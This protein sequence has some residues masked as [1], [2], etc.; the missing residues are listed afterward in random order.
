MELLMFVLNDIDLL[1]P[2]LKE[3]NS[4]GIKGCTILDSNGMGRELMKNQ[5]DQN[6]EFNIM[7]GTLRKLL[8][9]DLKNTKTLML[10][11]DKSKIESVVSS[12]EKIVG[13][14]DEPGT[15]ILVT[16]PLSFVK[17][18]KL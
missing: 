7:F 4:I 16:F 10:V 13:N 12:I 1:S 18:I 8:K 9:P 6:D 15:G 11:L 3:F 2:L 5:N 17:G 14:L